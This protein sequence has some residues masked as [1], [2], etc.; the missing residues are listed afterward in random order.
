MRFSTGRASRRA[1]LTR[2]FTPYTIPLVVLLATVAGTGAFLLHTSAP[3][4]P[5]YAPQHLSLVINVVV[6]TQHPYFDPGNFTVSDSSPV[7]VTITNYDTGAS[8]VPPLATL[9]RGVSGGVEYLTP[10]P[11]AKTSEVSFL[12]DTDISHTFAMDGGPYNVNVP[13][14]PAA[15]AGSPA[16]VQFTI[17]F[18]SPGSF[19]W[20]CAAICGAMPMGMGGGMAGVVTVTS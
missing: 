12:A 3:P 2:W 9:V 19:D 8:P 1:R 18:S 4:L 11:G 10:S 15:S 13:V 14:P 20:W 7:I 5:N 6:G 16:V 17:Y